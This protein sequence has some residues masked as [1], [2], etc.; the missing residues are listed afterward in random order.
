MSKLDP[1]LEFI[2]DGGADEALATKDTETIARFGLESYE[3]PA[4]KGKAKEQRVEAS[5]LVQFSSDPADLKKAGMT[6]HGVAG[7]VVTGRIA[8]KD[9]G[10][11]AKIDAV[12]RIEAA[13][14]MQPELDLS[15]PEIRADLVHA[16]PPGRRGSGVIVG[17]VDTGCDY[18]H[19][20]FQNSDGTT[21][22]LAIW[23]QGLTPQSGESSPTGFGFGVEYSEAD[24]NSALSSANPFNVVRHRDP[25]MH[26]THVTGIASGNGSIGVPPHEPAGTYVGVA[27]EADIIVVANSSNGTEGLGT[28]A[29]TLDAVNYIFQNA[30]EF[31]RPCV[32]N[33]SSR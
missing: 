21:R 9:L 15:V 28:S 10:K 20:A 33:M 25:F 5:V 24:I 14:S 19:P 22:I 32:V 13:R 11:L 16:G 1:Q 26:G 18:T 29:N 17:I 3:V 31:D 8:V 12:E 30:Q 4:K 7:D 27:P 2:V 23:D 6:V